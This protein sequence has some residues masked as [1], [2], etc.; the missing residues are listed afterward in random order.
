MLA[1]D[2][3]IVLHGPAVT[4]DSLPFSAIR[5]Y[6]AQY[7]AGWK[8]K[9]GTE[10]LLRPIRPEDEPLI[11]KFHAT[12]SDQSVFFRY[13]HME[14]LSSRVAHERLIRKCFVDYDREM[15]IVADHVVP[16]TGQHELLAVGRLTKSLTAQEGEVAVLV[17]DSYQHR[18]LGAELLRRLIQVG[19]DEKL[20]E[21]VASIL[22]E[23]TAM[24]SLANRCGF[25]LR[26]SDDPSVMVGVLRL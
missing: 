7:V 9:D 13:F 5:P 23:N 12:L 25:Q 21:L 24:W 14:K 11:V 15:A 26:K 10:I 3:R 16:E 8:M 2:A 18:G 17:T 6:P 22:P 19:R 20:Q 4:D 1:L